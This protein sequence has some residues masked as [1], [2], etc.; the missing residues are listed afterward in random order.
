MPLW[1]VFTPPPPL[2][3]SLLR[4]FHKS[5]YSSFAFVPFS[6]CLIAPLLF[7]PPLSFVV[8]LLATGCSSFIIRWNVFKVG[9]RRGRRDGGMH[10]SLV[11]NHLRLCE[12]VC[13]CLCIF[14]QNYACKHFQFFHVTLCV[15]CKFAVRII[16]CPC[17]CVCACLFVSLPVSMCLHVYISS[18]SY[19]L[20]LYILS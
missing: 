1:Y 2:P 15:P 18:L 9:G 3:S 5:I 17:V 6:S 14:T 7:L 16:V 10:G 11:R 20:C 4:L 13:V 19:P 12:C 8:S